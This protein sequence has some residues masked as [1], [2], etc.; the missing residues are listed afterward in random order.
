MCVAE[1]NTG[2]CAV[3]RGLVDP[4]IETIVYLADCS[5]WNLG[6][7]PYEEAILQMDVYETRTDR[8]IRVFRLSR[9]NP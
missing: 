1:A 6:G 7:K 5:G 4:Q 8:N 3:Y 2:V 9:I